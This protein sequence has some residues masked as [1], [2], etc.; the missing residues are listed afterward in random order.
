MDGLRDLMWSPTT[1]STKAQFW[2][3]K[4]RSQHP[5]AEMGT[6]HRIYAARMLDRKA[7]LCAQT[8]T[9][10][11]PLREIWDY[12]TDADHEAAELDRVASGERSQRVGA[13]HYALPGA[14]GPARAPTR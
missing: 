1:T 9:A 2:V 10:F 5:I 13:V 6:A 11:H 3:D 4:F 12:D 7:E 8:Y 14:D